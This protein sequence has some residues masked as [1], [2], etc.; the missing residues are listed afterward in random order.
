MSC[1]VKLKIYSDKRM[2]YHFVD[3]FFSDYAKALNYFNVLGT[4]WSAWEIIN[5]K[6]N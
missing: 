1:Y 5:F 3:G 4:N 6:G 2:N